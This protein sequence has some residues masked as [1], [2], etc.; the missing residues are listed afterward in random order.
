MKPTHEALPPG[1][2]FKNCE[3][4]NFQAIAEANLMAFHACT[5]EDSE[6]R[7]KY[8]ENWTKFER[9]AVQTRNKQ[10]N[11]KINTSWKNM[12]ADGK[13]LWDC[14]DWNGKAEI[15]TQPSN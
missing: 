6:S 2:N 1:E 13:K 10:L 4:S 15:K 3:S 9:L 5:E 7:S 12:K 8:I 14:I 11:S